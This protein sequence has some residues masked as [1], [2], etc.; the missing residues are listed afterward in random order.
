MIY[1][2]LT[3]DVVYKETEYEHLTNN[4]K[5]KVLVIQAEDKNQNREQIIAVCAEKFFEAQSEKI[6]VYDIRDVRT[7]Y[8][9]E[10]LREDIIGTIKPEC[11]SKKDRLLLSKIKPV[12]E[13]YKESLGFSAYCYLKDGRYCGPAYIHTMNELKAYVNLQMDYQYRVVICDRDDYIVL[14]MEDRSIKFPK[15]ILPHR[16]EVEEKK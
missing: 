13:N 10:C 8:V 11:L 14:E 2:R 9:K 3:P 5:N 12:I 4:I 7:G 1:N 15:L 6:P 16:N